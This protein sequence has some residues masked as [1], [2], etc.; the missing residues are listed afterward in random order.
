M[1]QRQRLPRCAPGV[2]SRSGRWAGPALVGWLCL[3][4]GH[5]PPPTRPPPPWA[6]AAPPQGAPRCRRPGPWPRNVSTPTHRPNCVDDE[7]RMLP[8][9]RFAVAMP[10]VYYL[11]SLHPPTRSS[12]T[13]SGP[14]VTSTVSTGPSTT[15]HHAPAVPRAHELADLAG[16]LVGLADDCGRDRRLHLAIQSGLGRAGPGIP[17]RHSPGLGRRVLVR[18]HRQPLDAL[19]GPARL[20]SAR[21]PNRPAGPDWWCLLHDQRA[22]HGGRRLRPF[23]HGSAAGRVGARRPW[24]AW[25]SSPHP[26]SWSPSRRPPSSRW[27]PRPTKQGYSKPEQQTAESPLRGTTT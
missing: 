6:G 4:R 21:H 18:A 14:P 8:V 26:A 24:P 27:P 22:E 16:L 25:P 1:T 2:V 7:L 11:V 5:R 20:P 13:S 12:L 10:G 19:P 17:S 15:R 3:D 23:L 9:A